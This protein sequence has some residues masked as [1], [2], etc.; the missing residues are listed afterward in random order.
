MPKDYDLLQRCALTFF[1]VLQETLHD[2][3][4]TEGT[5]RGHAMVNSLGLRARLV[6]LVAV[7]LVPVFGLFAWTAAS[8]QAD[9]LRLARST[10]QSQALLAAASQQPQVEA[11]RQLLG[12]LASAPPIKERLPRPCDEYL[13]NL[14]AAHPQ[15]TDLGALTL[16]GKVLCHSEAGR[17][18]ADASD[19][20][21]FKRVMESRQFSIG[22]YG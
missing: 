22:E 12:D 11:I 1:L 3:V 19:R 17:V 15:Y 7:A 2:S 6:L 16:D 20:P 14:K 5:R 9:A 4:Q 18:G 13:R 8:K 21:F 10:L